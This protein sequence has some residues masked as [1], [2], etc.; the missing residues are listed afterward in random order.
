MSKKK[1]SK[2]AAS[3]NTLDWRSWGIRALLLA[4]LIFGFVAWQLHPVLGNTA[5]LWA[6]LLGGLI[7]GWFGISY[8][9][10]NR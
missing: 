7:L 9:L 6:A 8:F 3:G 1:K 5:Y 2:S 10:L 4:A